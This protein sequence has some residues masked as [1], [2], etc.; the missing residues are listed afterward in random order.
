MEYVQNVGDS[1]AEGKRI[2]TLLS[3]LNFRREELNFVERVFPK[4]AAARRE[5]I[6]T[7]VHL[8]VKN[9]DRLL[10]DD[11][12]QALKGRVRGVDWVSSS[13]PKAITLVIERVR[14]DEKTIPE[15][16]ETITYSQTEVD[17]LSAALL[18]PRNASYIYEVVS[19]GAEIEYG[20]VVTAMQDGKQIFDEVIRGK[21]SGQH[22]RC[23]NSRIQN[24]FGGVS[25]AGFIANDDMNRRCSSSSQVTIDQLRKD[26]FSEVIQGVLKVP[27]IKATHEFN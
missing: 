22:R 20:F 19:G 11:I 17:L 2:E 18:M 4:Y 12:A 3:T 8:Q 7:R 5:E 21:V 24:V 14:N 10:S 15:R 27:P 1:S 16:S 25:S 26:V 9:G 6:S 23:Q 13:S